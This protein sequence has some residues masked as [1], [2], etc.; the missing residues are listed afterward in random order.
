[1]KNNF[2]GVIGTTQMIVVFII[3]SATI[4]GL[5]CKLP[6]YIGIFPLYDSS[7]P[8]FRSDQVLVWKAPGAT[9][10][11]FQFNIDSI[12]RAHPNYQVNACSNC[13]R[14]LALL[15][16]VDAAKALGPVGQLA[17][18][19]SG[20]K[21]SGPQG[22]GYYWCVNFNIA[23][24]DPIDSLDN[25]KTPI[26]LRTKDYSGTPVVVGVLDTGVDTSQLRAAGYL[27]AGSTKSCLDPRAIN[28]WN[29][30]AKNDDVQDKYKPIGHGATAATLITQQV[31]KIH[32]TPVKIL[33]VKIISDDGIANLY[34]VLC[35]MLYAKDRGAKII[36]ASFGY[37]SCPIGDTPIDSGA[38]LFKEYI[39]HYLTKDHI[40]MIAA[41]GNYDAFQQLRT[42]GRI[43]RSLD[44]MNFYP[45]SFAGDETMPNVITVTTGAKISSGY[46][47]SPRQNY[48]PTVVDIATIADK[49]M[50]TFNDAYVFENP[51]LNNSQIEGS[52]YA[53]PIFTGIVAANYDALVAVISSGQFDKTTIIPE[54]VR[55]GFIQSVPSFTSVR[56]GNVVKHLR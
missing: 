8:A 44:K 56:G 42:C 11:E 55:T 24:N 28:G 43:D 26:D 12:L 3:L 18:G 5:S 1:M 49:V 37:Y 4:F 16:G 41:A 29:F 9:P 2:K 27:Y 39:K 50:G 15:T 22:I 51:S 13:D 31:D 38:L 46:A 32:K 6:K 19:G 52:S 34:D 40:L 36:N 20:G 30:S 33:P 17:T 10:G 7:V 54:L 25:P 21:G 35:A 23:V 47:V 48:S 53:T 14:E 45:A